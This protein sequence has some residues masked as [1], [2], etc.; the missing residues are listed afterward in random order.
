MKDSPK[1]I[2]Y[3]V[4]GAVLVGQQPT[5]ASIPVTMATDQPPVAVTFTPPGSLD[6]VVMGKVVLGGGTV[7]VLQ[8]MRSTPYTEPATAAIRSVSSSSASDAAAGIGARTVAITWYSST[9][10]GPFVETV[11]MNGVTPVPLVSTTGRFYDSI[12]VVTAGSSGVNVGTITLHVDNAGVGTIG[13]IGIG[14]LVAAVGDNRTLWAHHY[15]ATNQEAHFSVLV[16]GIISGGSAT[17]G[18]F[19]L[20]QRR[21]LVANS[22]EVLI[23]DVVLAIGAF[24]RVFTFTPQVTGFAQI[25]AYGIPGTNNATLTASF[26]WSEVAA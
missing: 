2:L 5:A 24:E 21:P 15:I 4:D 26:D 16:A 11:T 25:I 13:T 3:N 6:G 22:A 12:E 9:G 8:V 7:G 18:Q 1:A 10:A 19:F 17:N 14:N 23:G 20:R